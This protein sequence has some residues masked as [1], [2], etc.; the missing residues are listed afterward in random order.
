MHMKVSKDQFEVNGDKLI[1]IPSGAVFWMGEKDV[2]E[3][4]W[5]LAGQPLESGYDYD[6]NELKQAAW[7]VF[8]LERTKCV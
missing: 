1:H 2:V 4:D 5:G 8:H 7:Q 3:C 6:R